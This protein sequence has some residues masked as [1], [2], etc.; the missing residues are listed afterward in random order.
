MMRLS[1]AVVFVA[2]MLSVSAASAQ[3][4]VTYGSA[5]KLSPV[6]YLP[7]LAAQEKDIFKKNGLNVDWI[8]SK[9]GPDFQ[10]NLAGS[11]VEIGSSTG[12]TD[13][14]A[15]SRG[16]PAI[17]VANLQPKDGFAVWVSSG[18]RFHRPQ[19]LKGAKLGVSRLS[20]VEHAY[21]LLAAKQ[22]GLGSDIQFIGTGGVRESLAVLVT[23]SIDGVILNPQ[24]LIELKLQGK[25]RQ[26]L[27]IAD[28]LPKPWLS[29]TITASKAMVEKR[30]D[31][32]RRTLNSLFEANRF[33]MS[34]QGKPWTI[35]KMKE[36]NKYSEQGSQE[37]YTTL[38][39]STDGKMDR[40][41]VENLTNFMTEFGLIKA[42]EVAKVDTL[43]TDQFIR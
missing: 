32:V 38:N 7:I 20:G 17:I 2:T 14:P 12:G 43:F 28:Y 21:G 18:S 23:G 36:E 29:Y 40:H 25:V 27:S 41:A 39:L 15:I 31:V 33:I 35:A 24:N 26:L 22:L 34:A 13:I 4:K 5:I 16:V 42:G 19:D 11:I 1:V 6:Y 3:D 37:V 10:R 8:P 9:S 30:P